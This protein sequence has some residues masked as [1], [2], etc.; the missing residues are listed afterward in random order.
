MTM[1]TT[2][3]MKANRLLLRLT[4]PGRPEPWRTYPRRSRK[5]AAEMCRYKAFKAWQTQVYWLAC[6]SRQGPIARGPVVLHVVFYLGHNPRMP[7]IDNLRKGLSDALEGAVY[8]NDS[9]V[10]YGSTG[11]V[12]TDGEPR[13]VI[14]CWELAPEPARAEG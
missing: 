3:T 11:R 10:Q 12:L 14:E 7:D 2:T 4:V 8:A 13:T 1:T 6:T 5:H 9:Q